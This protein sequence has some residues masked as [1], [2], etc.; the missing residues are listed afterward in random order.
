HH[1][2]KRSQSHGPSGSLFLC[3]LCSS[4]DLADYSRAVSSSVLLQPR[5]ARCLEILPHRDR[6]R[7]ENDF[8]PKLHKTTNWC[9]NRKA[10]NNAIDYPSAIECLQAGKHPPDSQ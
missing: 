6:H 8:P 1:H 5:T 2:Q 3:S 10:G 7:K 9:P 4:P